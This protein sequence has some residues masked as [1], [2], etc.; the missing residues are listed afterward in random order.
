[1]P[2]H[3]P[4]REVDLSLPRIAGVALCIGDGYISWATACLT[5]LGR[6][7]WLHRSGISVSALPPQQLA[8]H[9]QGQR[10]EQHA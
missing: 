3:Q 6:P 9:N 4:C 1:M 10:S 2:C 5:R 7:S 8:Q